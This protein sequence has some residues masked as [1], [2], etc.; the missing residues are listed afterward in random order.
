MNRT[1][2]DNPEAHMVTVHQHNGQHIV[3]KVTWY[4]RDLRPTRTERYIRQPGESLPTR[5][6]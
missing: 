2:P 1:Y 5:L 6:G 4:D 3:T